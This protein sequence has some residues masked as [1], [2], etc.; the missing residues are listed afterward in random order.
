MLASDNRDPKQDVVAPYSPEAATN[1][2]EAAAHVMGLDQADETVLPS[3]AGIPETQIAGFTPRI[4][5]LQPLSL[6]PDDTFEPLRDLITDAIHYPRKYIR[7]K[8]QFLSKVVEKNLKLS[9]SASSKKKAALPTA[10]TDNG[11][12]NNKKR[13]RE[14]VVGDEEQ[15]PFHESTTSPDCFFSPHSSPLPPTY[16]DRYFSS[17][18]VCVLVCLY[19]HTVRHWR[20]DR[21][22]CQCIEHHEFYVQCH[23]PLNT[24]KRKR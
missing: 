21:V 15:Q 10:G 9:S 18:Y 6:G 19:H 1:P 2:L 22:Q 23:K 13:A 24:E 20:D 7:P 17:I 16:E 5:P 12:G 4:Q 8:S 11:D 3:E 14:E